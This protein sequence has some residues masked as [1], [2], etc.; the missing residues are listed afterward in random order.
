MKMFFV[1]LKQFCLTQ[2]NERFVDFL[3]SDDCAWIMREKKLAIHIDT[4]NIYF[5]DFNT[6]GSF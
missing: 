4:G 2:R 6:S 3:K 5:D 1:K